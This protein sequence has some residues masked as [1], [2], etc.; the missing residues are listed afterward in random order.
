MSYV[1]GRGQ[2]NFLYSY[3][4]F[5]CLQCGKDRLINLIGF[6]VINK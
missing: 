1:D 2:C 6:L 4:N 5:L 3:N